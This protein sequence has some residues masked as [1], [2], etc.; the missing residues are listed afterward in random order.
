MM[1][2]TAT[3][4]PRWGFIGAGRMATALIRGMLRAGTAT[5]EA[6]TASDPLEAARSALAAESGIS[7]VESN[8]RVAHKSDVLVLAVKPQSMSHVLEHLRHAVT[9]EHLV[10]SIAAGVSLTTLAESL[11]P[12]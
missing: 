8:V 9:P 1:T 3:A 10:I 11:G 12:D 6:I 2:E 4:R 7:V 5:P